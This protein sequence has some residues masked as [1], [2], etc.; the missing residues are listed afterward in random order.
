MSSCEKPGGHEMDKQRVGHA[1]V[2][3]V[4]EKG[5]FLRYLCT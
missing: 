3:S 2:D 5:T 4:D 1:V